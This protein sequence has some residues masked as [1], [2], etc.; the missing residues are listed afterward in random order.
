MGMG[1]IVKGQIRVEIYS[2]QY[3]VTTYKGNH[4]ITSVKGPPSQG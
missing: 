2:I 3:T 4:G 1:R